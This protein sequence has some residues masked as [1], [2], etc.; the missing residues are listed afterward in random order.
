MLGLKELRKEKK[1][2]Q[3]ELAIKCGVIR[4]TISEIECGRKKPSIK[5]AK[6][7]EKVLDVKWSIFFE[8]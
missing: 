1:L 3:E 4:Q 2:T 8:E 5:L 7:L 6:K